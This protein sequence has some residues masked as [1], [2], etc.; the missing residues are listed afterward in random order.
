MS[1][2]RELPVPPAAH[3]DQRSTEVVRAWVANQGLHCSL[4]IG[5]WQ[6]KETTVWGILLSDV[7]RHIADALHK[8]D[9]IERA[10]VLAEIA[11]HFNQELDRPTAPTQ[12]GFV[13]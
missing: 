3:Q 2:L 11:E 5:L 1:K 12:G 6:M 9:G 4:N 8:R 7:A 10:L 13:E